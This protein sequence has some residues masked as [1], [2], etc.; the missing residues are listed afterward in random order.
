MSID[1]DQIFKPLIEAFFREFMELFCPDEGALIDFSRLEFLGEEHFT[2]T[3]RGLRRFLDLVVKA[4]LKS[5]GER[6]VLVHGEFEA[7]RKERDLPRRMF[8]Y[9]CQLFL[10]YGTDRAMVERWRCGQP[11]PRCIRISNPAFR[12]SEN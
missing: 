3:S 10:R 4:G 7:S 6:F 5:G 11:V 12:A 1:H 9:Y 2:D 8:R